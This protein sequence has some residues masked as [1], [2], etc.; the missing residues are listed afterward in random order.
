MLLLSPLLRCVVD[1]LLFT[2][3]LARHAP[4]VSGLVTALAVRVNP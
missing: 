2:A 3:L 1:C 4:S